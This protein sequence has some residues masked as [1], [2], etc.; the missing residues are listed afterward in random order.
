M[1]VQLSMQILYLST[2]QY[3]HP[4]AVISVW[5]G[6]FFVCFPEKLENDNHFCKKGLLFRMQRAILFGR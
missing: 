4:R 1:R 6:G 2:V 3:H 5:D